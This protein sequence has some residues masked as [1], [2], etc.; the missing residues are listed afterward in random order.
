MTIEKEDLIRDHYKATLEKGSL[1][2]GPYCACGQ[3]LN[4][5]YFCDKCNRECHCRQIVCDN[6]ATLNMVKNYIKKSSQFSG[7]KVKLAGEG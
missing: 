7:F 4:E 2:M 6:E 3:A 5:D 1:V